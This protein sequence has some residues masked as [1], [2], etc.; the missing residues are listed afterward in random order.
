MRVNKNNREKIREKNR[1]KIREK[2]TEKL[3]YKGEI[4][5]REKWDKRNSSEGG[6]LEERRGK[7]RR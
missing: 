7:N 2:I 3:K 4:E 1:E 6:R 5:R